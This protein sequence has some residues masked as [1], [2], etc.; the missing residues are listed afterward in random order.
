MEMQR[1]LNRQG[2]SAGQVDGLWGPNTSAALRRYQ[3]KNGLQQSGQLDARTLAMLGIAGAAHP[4]AAAQTAAVPVETPPAPSPGPATPGTV[5]QGT[6]AAG[7]NVQ[8]VPA[9]V[10][11]MPQVAAPNAGVAAGTPPVA[12]V[13]AGTPP[14]AGVVDRNTGAAGAAGDNNQAVAT[15]GAN[16]A[17]PAQGANS[18]S[19]GEARQRIES[20]GYTAVSDLKKGVDGVWRGHGTKNGASVGVWL[21]YKGNVG[22]Q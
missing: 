2:F 17:Q 8:V 1:K 12:G 18:F 13:A 6:G 3:A 21:D 4:A 19:Q 5:D 7:G 10:P 14:G 22:Q 11:N 20:E 16:A 9:P 15:T